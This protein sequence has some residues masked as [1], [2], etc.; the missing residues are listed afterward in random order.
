MGKGREE[1]EKKKEKEILFFI[2][3]ITMNSFRNTKEHKEQ[4]LSTIW[5]E[6]E[7]MAVMSEDFGWRAGPEQAPTQVHQKEPKL[8]PNT[9][10]H[11]TRR[12]PG[13]PPMSTTP[14]SCLEFSKQD[15]KASSFL[16]P[17]RDRKLDSCEGAGADTPVPGGSAGLQQ[18][19]TSYCVTHVTQWESLRP[20]RASARSPGTLRWLLP[21]H[22]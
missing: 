2:K 19:E 1:E 3:K 8:R 14:A 16:V 13:P 22:A 11:R 12:R 7:N 15:S 9:G 4:H 18:G 21:S 5:P 20:H 6:K 17:S 10:F